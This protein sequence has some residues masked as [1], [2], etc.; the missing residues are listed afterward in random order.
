MVMYMISNVTDGLNFHRINAITWILVCLHHKLMLHQEIM[1]NCNALWVTFTSGRARVVELRPAR[2][3][4][5]K[6]PSVFQT[7]G[8]TPMTVAGISLRASQQ[9]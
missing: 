6:L 3:H 7:N 5:T 2:V 1:N 9:G 4:L 8:T